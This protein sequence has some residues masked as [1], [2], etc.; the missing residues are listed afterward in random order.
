MAVDLRV[1]VAVLVLLGALPALAGGSSSLGIAHRTVA[2]PPPLNVS[3][4][5]V[6]NGG[7]YGGPASVPFHAVI[8]GG[9]PPYNY[10]WGFG[11]GSPPSYSAD[12]THTYANPMNGPYYATLSVKDATGSM[13]HD[14]QRVLFVYPPCATQTKQGGPLD[15]DFLILVA[16][17]VIAVVALVAVW[18]RGRARR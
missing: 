17:V 18:R 7:C 8:T 9:S 13:A 15:P 14:T 5:Y 1:V 12:P 16:G 11:D 3:F 6:A 4:S 10:T 2:T